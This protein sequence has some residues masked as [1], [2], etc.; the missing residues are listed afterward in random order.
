MSGPLRILHLEDSAS[1]AELIRT[2]LEEDGL[3]SIIE[4][5]ETRE[6]YAA[7]L[8]RGG[9]DV[10][11]ADY[12]LPSFDGLSAL[13]MVRERDR[14][15]PFIFVSGTI[16]EDK[17]AETFKNGATDYVLKGN[18]SRLR[19]A[20]QRALKEAEEHRERQRAE[21][22]LKKSEEFIQSIL[23]SVD[24][25]FVVVDRDYRILTAN[26]A[27]CEQASKPLTE[28][29]G[30]YCYEILHHVTSP[31]HELEQYCACTR[32][33]AMLRSWRV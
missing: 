3:S 11:L 16:G 1:D 22:E 29:I 15:V 31:C 21:A 6:E 23:S 12:T 13:H 20:V 33:F 18:L 8:A 9:Y 32:T 26:R 5:V 7:R 28:I 17:A 10:I 19:P 30:K 25:A 4:L 27:Y 14:D 24:E 2:R